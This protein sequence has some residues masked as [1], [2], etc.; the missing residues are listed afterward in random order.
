MIL[1]ELAEII[2][3]INYKQEHISEKSE[4]VLLQVK[5]FDK[6]GN[7]CDETCNIKTTSVQ[8]RHLLQNNDI[9]FAAKGSRHYSVVY[10][11]QF[12]KAA[13]TSSFFIIRNKSEKILPDYI[14]WYINQKPAQEYFRMQGGNTFLSSV[15]KRQLENLIVP[16]P[17]I[18]TQ[19]III[20]VEA[21]R[22]KELL[23]IHEIKLQKEALI[24]YCLIKKIN[25][26][27]E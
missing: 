11:N 22:K 8:E 10:K 27:N 13:A 26:I 12:G 19:N 15:N 6:D 9:L 1:K 16:V 4:T 17:S 23:L 25:E 20:K 24:E 2:S 21:L 3:G 7:L 14:S 18:E 5:D